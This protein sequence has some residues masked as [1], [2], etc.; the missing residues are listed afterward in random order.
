M[1]RRTILVL[2][3]LAAAP[4]LFA[5]LDRSAVSRNGLDT[6]PCSV[7]SPCRSFTSAMAAT[8]PGG[9]IV[10]L[11]SGGYG[12]FNIDKAVTISGAP[13]A[14]AA[15]TVTSGNGIVISAG[16]S[17]RVILRNLVLIGSGG[18]LGVMESAADQVSISACLIRGFSFAGIV[19]TN[20]ATAL[21]V[22]RSQVLDGANIGIKVEQSGTMTSHKAIVTNSLIQGNSSGV[23]VQSAGQTVVSDSTITGNSVGVEVDG[24]PGVA[25]AT[26]ERCTLAHNNYGVNVT[27][28]IAIPTIVNLSQNVISLNNTGVQGSGGPP[29]PTVNTFGNNRFYH[30]IGADLSGISMTPVSMH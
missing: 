19:I 3:L 29:G 12:P 23:L 27:A 24:G 8:N 9:E 26:I 4:A 2:I 17:D 20:T 1:S 16:P 6:N 28:V 15:I 21:S 11:D 25:Y 13:G 5:T 14:H 10:A 7:A 22:D 30:N 18:A